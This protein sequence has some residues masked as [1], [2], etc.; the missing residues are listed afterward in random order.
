[1]SCAIWSVLPSAR[2]SLYW[3][4][5]TAA[6]A[7]GFV[8]DREREWGPLSP[9]G[10]CCTTAPRLSENSSSATPKVVH[11]GVPPLLFCPSVRLLFR[12]CTGRTLGCNAVF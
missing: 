10:G 3:R 7:P 12:A 11:N 4:P 9:R 6:A 1:M 5:I 8:Q 2:A